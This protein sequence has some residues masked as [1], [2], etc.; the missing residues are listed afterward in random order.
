M[1]GTPN[2]ATK[3]L[4]RFTSEE[5]VPVD[6]ECSGVLFAART[7][8]GVARITDLD[9]HKADF[10]EHFPPARTRQASGNSS[11]PEVDI[12]YST[13]RNRVP[14][15]DIRVLKVTARPK[16]TKYFLEHLLFVGAQVDHAVADHDIGPAVFDRH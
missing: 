7:A 4:Y 5:R 10:L 11:R 14:I 13:V 16:H 6:F 9:I 2:T 3:S 15:R 8:E 1:F 12:L